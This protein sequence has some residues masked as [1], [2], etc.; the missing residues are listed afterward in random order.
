MDML[1][2][3]HIAG[4]DKVVPDSHG[5]KRTLEQVSRGWGGEKWLAMKTAKSNDVKMASLLISNWLSGHGKIVT[6][7]SKARHGAPNSMVGSADV[8]HPPPR[9]KVG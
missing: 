9:F 3:Q 6:H 2:H 8:G 7:V 5:F 4:D 1:R